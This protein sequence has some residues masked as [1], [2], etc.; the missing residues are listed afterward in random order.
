MVEALIILALQVE[1]ILVVLAE[2]VQVA[3]VLADTLEVFGDILVKITFLLT[4][5]QQEQI[6]M[7]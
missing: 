4:K 1:V 2:V 7:F 6:Y 3:V 5:M